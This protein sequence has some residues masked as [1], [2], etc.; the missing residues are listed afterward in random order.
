MTH[1]SNWWAQCHTVKG[2]LLCTDKKLRFFIFFYSECAHHS[3]VY[4]TMYWLTGNQ[5]HP[6]FLSNS[7]LCYCCILPSSG[8]TYKTAFPH[9][10]HSSLLSWNLLFISLQPHHQF[11]KVILKITIHHCHGELIT[12]NTKVKCAS[13]ILILFE[14]FQSLYTRIIA[15]MDSFLAVRLFAHISKAF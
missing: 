12:S 9:Q 8:T 5:Q 15:F 13:L 6:Y 1:L 14:I 10:K 11:I 4:C 3:F 2:V 7:L